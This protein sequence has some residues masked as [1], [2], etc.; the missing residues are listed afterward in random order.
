MVVLVLMVVLT[1]VRVVLM[2]VL[3]VCMVVLMVA[4][5][6]SDAHAGGNG[7]A[8]SDD[9]FTRR[10]A[11]QWI[12]PPRTSEPTHEPSTNGPVNLLARPGCHMLSAPPHLGPDGGPRGAPSALSV[13]PTF[14]PDGGS[15][16]WCGKGVITPP[17]PTWRGTHAVPTFTTIT[18]SAASQRDPSM[19]RAGVQ[20]QW[21]KVFR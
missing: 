8:W 12:Y 4:L 10:M 21:S 11:L 20:Q 7:G 18:S 1:V 16:P 14:R 19:P 5:G 9:G 17:T 13:A 6:G 3:V 15:L 2:L